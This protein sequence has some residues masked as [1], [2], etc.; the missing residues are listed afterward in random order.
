[1]ITFLGEIDPGESEFDV[2]S[3]KQKYGF[4]KNYDK[5]LCF[6]TL[7]GE[8]DLGESEFDLE[9]IKQNK[10]NDDV[11]VSACTGSRAD[12][13]AQVELGTA[14]PRDDLGS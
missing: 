7:R 11:S 3:I 2:E 4:C 8:I 14:G 1:M 12:T 5:T 6:R 9:S 10:T 13:P